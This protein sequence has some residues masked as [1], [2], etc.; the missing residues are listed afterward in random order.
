MTARDLNRLECGRIVAG[1]RK[2]WPLVDDGVWAGGVEAVWPPVFDEQRYAVRVGR[3]RGWLV[4]IEPMLV[5]DRLALAVPDDLSGYSHGWCYPKGGAAG[6]AVALWRAR[7][8]ASIG[9][10]ILTS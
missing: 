7:S 6:T 3:V 5:N 2:L 9:A 8:L 1:V 4:M 10:L